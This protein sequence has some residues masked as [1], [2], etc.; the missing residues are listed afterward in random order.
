MSWREWIKLATIF[1]PLLFL[2]SPAIATRIRHPD[3]WRVIPVAA[4]IGLL[5]FG[6]ELHAGGVLLRLVE[7]PTAAMTDYNRG[8]S[9][10]VVL[11]FPVMAGILS[12]RQTP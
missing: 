11:A 7:G 6:I 8:L 12:A 1:L 3:F 2:S 4:V 10:F 9:Y 5:A